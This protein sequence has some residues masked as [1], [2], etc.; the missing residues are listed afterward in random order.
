METKRYIP[1]EEPVEM[2]VVRKSNWLEVAEWVGAELQNGSIRF[3]GRTVSGDPSFS[4]KSSAE[5]YQPMQLGAV[6]TKNTVTGVF[7]IMTLEELRLRYEPEQV[8]AEQWTDD[9]LKRNESVISVN[10]KWEPSGLRFQM[11]TAVVAGH[12]V[13]KYFCTVCNSVVP[14]LQDVPANYSV[15]AALDAHAKEVHQAGDY[16]ILPPIEDKDLK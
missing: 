2:V 3:L 11:H 7:T 13:G 9:D 8:F 1:K 16:I 14:Q 15:P 5:G 6:I 10:D 4:V 12:N